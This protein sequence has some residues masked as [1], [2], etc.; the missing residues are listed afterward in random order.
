MFVPRRIV[1]SG[2]GV[3]VIS[4]LGTL[5]ILEKQG[6]L[7]KVTEYSGVS[8]GAW[9]AFLLAGGSS[10]KQV[11][12]LTL[13][14]NFSIIRNLSTDG[15][16]GF[17]ETFGLDDGTQL[18]IFLESM[19]RVVLKLDPAITF[20][21]FAKK[22]AAKG[23]RCW[24]TDLHRQRAREFSLRE[25][26]SVRIIDAL[27]ASMALPLYYTP[28]PDPITGNLLTDGGVQGNLPLEH[29]T[30]YEIESCLAL[31]FCNK[32]GADSATSAAPTDIMSFVN[33]ILSCL[34]YT[35][36]KAMLAKW[37]HRTILVPV[38]H[39]PAWNFELSRED[40]IMLLEKGRE[41]G[42][43]WIDNPSLG[44]RVAKPRLRSASI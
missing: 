22:P 20:A 34:I 6:R 33:A 2:G 17:P 5:E 32:K 44:H 27:R 28:F 42:Q 29:M 19:T 35:R 41:A 9:L 14:L 11:Q 23:F 37:S 26:P 39:Y 3:K 7:R 38:G 30:D 31:G 18:V 16:I 8:A 4:L 40:R 15:L 43:T 21:E 1:L 12:H 24:A 36:V 10:I 13:D 25:T